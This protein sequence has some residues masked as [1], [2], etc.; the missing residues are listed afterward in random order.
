MKC[1]KCSYLG[2]ETGDRCK[3]CGYDF[4][5]LAAA[6]PAMADDVLT[7]RSPLDDTPSSE[8]WLSQLDATL[9]PER[10]ALDTHAAADEFFDLSFTPE[11]VTPIAAPATEPLA[12]DGLDLDDTIFEAPD[13]AVPAPT[14]VPVIEEPIAFEDLPDIEA[15]PA[16]AEPAPIAELPDVEPLPPSAPAP[17][18]TLHAVPQRGAADAAALPL[19]TPASDVDEEEDAPLIKLPAAP[20]A[21]LAVRRT[22]DTPRLRAVPKPLQRP[23]PEPAL[24]F[25]EEELDP[26]LHPGEEDPLDEGRSRS[27]VWS[28]P[29]SNGQPGSAGSRLAAAG[30]DHLILASVDL[31]VVYF[32]LRMT[33]LGIADWSTIPIA[34]FVA[35]LVLL[36]FAYFTAFTA[37]GGQTIGKMAMHI[38]VV[39]DD[40]ATVPGGQAA[41]RALVGLVSVL[42][43]GLAYVPA[44]FGQRRALHDRATHTRVVGLESA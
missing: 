29:A 41:R 42:T 6:E 18:V 31:A 28:G 24:A 22:P 1:P 4:S 14:A 10:P 37:I 32:T 20:R 38:R 44:L 35:F 26:D 30:I 39:T 5:L 34:P 2:F 9:Q 16:I 7:L 15:L 13:D 25:A 12:L 8:I 27:R 3:N 36:K 21:P 11:Q 19:F 17:R 40:D 23:E 43:V 33:G